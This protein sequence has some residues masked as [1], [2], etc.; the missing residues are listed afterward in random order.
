M[1]QRGPQKRQRVRL[2]A[3]ID[4]YL[5][6]PEDKMLRKQAREAGLTIPA[7]IRML[8]R[9]YAGKNAPLEEAIKR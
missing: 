3:R 9:E 1:T 7:Y 8:I 2:D 6:G 4:V 5:S